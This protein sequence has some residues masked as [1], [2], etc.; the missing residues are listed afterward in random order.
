CNPAN[1]QCSPQTPKVC[2]AGLT[3]DPSDG[4]CKDLCAGV[5]CTA[6]DLCHLPGTCSSATGQ[7]SPQTA[8]TCPS[9]QTCDPSDGQCKDL[10]ATVTC[11]PGEACDPGT[12]T[13]RAVF[14]VPQPQ[15]GRSFDLATPCGVATDS[16]A[17][18]YVT[19]PIFSTAPIDFDGHPVA[20]SGDADVMVARFD[21]TGHAVWAVGFADS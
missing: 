3:C 5:V 9:G 18:T 10:C 12:G 15:A 17:Q 19:C 4:Q 8:V 11:P 20:S 16:A 1:A 13:C 14:T 6:T 7:C 2:A 21:G